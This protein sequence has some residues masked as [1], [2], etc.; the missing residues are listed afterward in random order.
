VNRWQSEISCIAQRIAL[1]RQRHVDRLIDEDNDYWDYATDYMDLYGRHHFNHELARGIG[2]AGRTCREVIYLL[3][4]DI[5]P[6]IAIAAGSIKTDG[7]GVGQQVI[8]DRM[9][10]ILRP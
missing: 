6:R 8:Q 2:C 1:E 4:H 7:Q 10:L 3:D 5:K 9:T